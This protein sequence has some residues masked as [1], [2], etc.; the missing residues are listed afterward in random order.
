MIFYHGSHLQNL[1]KLT[2][3]EETSRFGGDDKLLH[4]A[5]IYL[6]SSESEAEAY[7]TGGSYYEVEV[8]GDIFDSTDKEV[9]TQFIKS[10]E[11]ELQVNLLD[12]QDIQ[13]MIK[14][15]NTGQLSGAYLVSHLMVNIG[16]HEG[17]YNDII[18]DVFNEDSDLLREKLETLFFYKL[19]LVNNKDISH[20]LLCLDHSGNGLTILK[21]IVVD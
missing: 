16:N 6:T 20:W 21:E 19:I 13:T 8:S 14:Q 2:Y 18:V 5:A 11:K 1:K 10:I 9:V 12:N 4:G 15:I 7:A 17:L 3:S